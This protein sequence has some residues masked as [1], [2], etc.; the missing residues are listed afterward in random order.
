VLGSL[1]SAWIRAFETCGKGHLQ[2]LHLML[3]KLATSALGTW[4]ETLQGEWREEKRLRGGDVGRLR[5]LKSAWCAEFC[6]G[7]ETKM[8]ILCLVSMCHPCS[9]K[10]S[11]NHGDDSRVQSDDR[12]DCNGDVGNDQQPHNHQQ[13][14][15]A[16]GAKSRQDHITITNIHKQTQGNTNPNH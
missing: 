7:K 14:Q 9:I 10:C 5:Q 2:T 3:C 15:K 6:Y 8:Y 13:V 4:G 1:R 16:Q 11:Y 12:Q